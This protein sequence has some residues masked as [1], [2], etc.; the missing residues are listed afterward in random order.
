SRYRPLSSRYI[1]AVS[2]GSPTWLDT[3]SAS[4]SEANSY[5]GGTFTKGW[6]GL[7]ADYGRLR[8]VE[9]FAGRVEADP[10]K[11]VWDLAQTRAA[12]MRPS[13]RPARSAGANWIPA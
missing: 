3:P 1:R 8:G 9:R 2:F 12:T 6:S 13:L 11:E 5:T 10:L 7:C 4:P